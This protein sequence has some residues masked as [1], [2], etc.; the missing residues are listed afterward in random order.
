MSVV[1]VGVCLVS[2]V[3]VRVNVVISS[4]CSHALSVYSYV[5]MV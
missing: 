4:V 5:V 2:V 3:M 1:M